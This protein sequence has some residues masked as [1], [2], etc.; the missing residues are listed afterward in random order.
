MILDKEQV[1]EIKAILDAYYIYINP[2]LIRALEP[3]KNLLKYDQVWRL[4]EEVY[5]A[6]SLDKA[7]AIMELVYR[8][9]FKYGS[10]RE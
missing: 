2:Q 10:E 3:G 6:V 7:L 5:K 4:G 8:V 9:V 1:D